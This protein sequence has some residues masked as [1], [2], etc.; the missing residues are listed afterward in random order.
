MMRKT[1]VAVIAVAF[2][3]SGCVSYNPGTLRSL[4]DRSL[5][6]SEITLE[7][8]R[9]FILASQAAIHGA[10]SSFF[11]LGKAVHVEANL[12]EVG[13]G[14]GDGGDCHDR[15][16]KDR[17]RDHRTGKAGEGD[18]GGDEPTGC[19][20]RVKIDQAKRDRDDVTQDG[21][22]QDGKHADESL[23]LQVD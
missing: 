20:H 17:G 2:V 14:F 23:A 19:P 22:Q 5:A 7:M 12:V 9:D 16:A 15:D 6:S 13:G 11:L 21:A 18:V 3:L 8:C 4:S 10:D 1:F